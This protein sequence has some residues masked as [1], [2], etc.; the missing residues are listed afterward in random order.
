[1]LHRR[2]GVSEYQWGAR[3]APC[4]LGIC[5]QGCITVVPLLPAVAGAD[6]ATHFAP[7]GQA[8][9]SF[10]AL[11]PTLLLCPSQFKEGQHKPQGSRVVDARVYSPSSFRSSFT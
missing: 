6:E 7:A 1:M 8:P 4:N 10:S 3:S 5:R 11:P 9:P 2:L